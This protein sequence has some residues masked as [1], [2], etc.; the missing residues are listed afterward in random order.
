MGLILFMAGVNINAGIRR[1]SNLVQH[2]K[3]HQLRQALIIL[4]L[5]AMDEG[6]FLVF[7]SKELNVVE[8]V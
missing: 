4:L 1:L 6:Q 5:L 8:G 2:L 7:L 3:I